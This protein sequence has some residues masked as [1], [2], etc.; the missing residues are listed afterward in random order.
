MISLVIPT[1]NRPQFLG[2]LLLYYKEMKLPHR[3]AVADSSN[4]QSI[5]ANAKLVAAAKNVLEIDHLVYSSTT[6]FN[7]KLIQVLEAINTSYVIFC[8]DDDFITPRGIEQAA[9]YLETHK[10]YSVASGRISAITAHPASGGDPGY[11]L[12]SH[13][14]AQRTIDDDNAAVRLKNHLSNYTTTFY[15]VHRRAQLLR[16]LHLTHELT[17]D[18]RF[19]ELLPSCLSLIQGKTICLDLLYMVRQAI[20]DSTATKADSWT[21]LLAQ[22][23]YP[24]R[25]ALFRDCLVKELEYAAQLD[26]AQADEVVTQ[27]FHSYLASTIYQGATAMDPK[28]GSAVGNQTYKNL[29]E[30]LKRVIMIMPAAARHA[31]MEAQALS[32]LKAPR[33]TYRKL[34]RR[35]EEMSIDALL[36]QRS[37]FH[38]DFAPIFEYLG[39]YPDGIVFSSAG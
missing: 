10:D 27:A 19:G 34:Q 18:Y 38:S 30:R 32:M 6:P 9:N 13:R 22:D 29:I 15:S 1:Y 23:D 28:N 37:P 17:S 4:P 5:S 24:E 33:S 7:A 20:T 3:I 14:Y 12:L 16:N 11:G 36:D 21:N 31:F 8:G 25:Y 26:Q 2:R 39:R 35:R